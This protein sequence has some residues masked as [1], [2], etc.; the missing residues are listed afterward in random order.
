V[1]NK[2]VFDI[3]TR[4]PPAR[5]VYARTLSDDISFLH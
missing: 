2:P 3:S 1:S 4:L 5:R